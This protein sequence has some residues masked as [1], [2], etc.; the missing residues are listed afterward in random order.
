M[1][2]DNRKDINSLLI[3]IAVISG[4]WF[5][6]GLIYRPLLLFLLMFI[7]LTLFFGGVFLVYYNW[8]KPADQ[9]EKDINIATGIREQLELCKTELEKNQRENKGIRANIEDLEYTLDHTDE[10]DTRNRKESKRILAGFYRELELRKAKIEF[11]ETCKTKL[12]TLL[13]NFRY[14]KTLEEKQTKLNALQEDHLE[15]LAKME[16]LRSDMAYNVRFLET[17]EMLSLRMLKS[18]SLDTAQQLQSELKDITK[19]LRRL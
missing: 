13:Y 8:K 2:K 18:N 19:E 17:I 1:L 7:A 3:W 15:D 11:Y 5:V 12:D 14:A 9:I 16:A 10:L 6:V 4:I